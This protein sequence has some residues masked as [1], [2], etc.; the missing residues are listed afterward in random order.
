MS[1]RR[2]T[3]GQSFTRAIVLEVHR[4]YRTQIEGKHH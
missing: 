1:D 4:K 3:C 2:T